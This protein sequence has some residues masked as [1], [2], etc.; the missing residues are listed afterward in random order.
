LLHGE[1][2]WTGEI[3]SDPRGAVGTKEKD[4]RLYHIIK[5]DDLKP[6]GTWHGRQ[7]RKSRQPA[8]QRTCSE[9]WSA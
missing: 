3:K 6:T 7:D 8:K 4:D 5:L 2:V 1:G 9:N